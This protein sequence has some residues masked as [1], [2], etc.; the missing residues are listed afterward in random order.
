MSEQ[1]WY[2]ITDIDKLDTP[3]LVVYPHR[4]KQNI[5]MLKYMIDDVYRLRP[6]VKTFK[7]KEVVLLMMDAG[8]TKFKCAT[9]AEAEMLAMCGAPDVL[10]AYQPV[11][12]KIGRFMRLVISY[13]DTM[14]SC[15]VDN[16]DSADGINAAA[17]KNSIR[18]D[19]CID[20][21]V[22][23]NRTGIA[24]V[25]KAMML[26]MYCNSLPG[27]NNIGLHAYDGHIHEADL[28]YR[29]D[30]CNAAYEMVNKLQLTLKERG[31]PEP[32]IIAGG[33]PTFSIHAKRKGIEV[34]PGTFVYWDRG[35]QQSFAE[36]SFLPAALVVAKVISLPTATTIC[37]D[38]G[39]KS[40]ASE[41]MLDKRIYFLNAPKLRM[42]SQS[43]EHLVAE[44]GEGHNY[45][46]GDV[47]YGLP[48]HICPTVSQY[49]R[50]I[51]IENGT[52]T[53]EWKNIARDRKINV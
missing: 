39:H 15:L 48:W 10:L 34:S 31:Y 2:T 38:S 50:A 28:E 53:G 22:G 35:F 17:T 3:A 9:I 5:D 30:H 21:N 4:V 42:I 41:N 49:E 12:P 6:H 32:N 23:M 45:Q 44:A 24:S 16:Q 52:I 27:I 33:S 13:P 29:T 20:L 7:N 51:T 36:E 14:F 1:H 40:V 46:I 26:Y 8:I 11:G 43:E 25:N 47:L 19:I 18:I 37:I